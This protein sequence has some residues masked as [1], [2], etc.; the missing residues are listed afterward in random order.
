VYFGASSDAVSAAGRANPS[1][2]LVSQTRDA[3]TYEPAGLLELGKTY[4]WR[5]D[6]VN[7]PPA[8]T[9][10]KG[11]VWSF[12]VEPVA[13]PIT[14][15][16]AT[17]SSYQAGMG[18]EKTIDGS[19]LNTTD[20]HSTQATDMWLSNV[21]GLQPTWIQYEFDTVCK[22]HEMWVWNSNQAI[23]PSFGL[24]IKG[25]TVE[26]STNGTDW[27]PL[28]GVPEF[29]QASGLAGYPHNTTVK[30]AGAVAKY[31]RITANSNWGGLVKQYSLSEVRFF[32]VPVLA[33]EPYPA[34]GSTGVAVDAV[35][36]WRAGREAVSHRVYLSSDE[37][38]VTTGA[39]LAGTTS[40]SRYSTD[41]LEFGRTYY[42]KVNEVNE[43]G[44]PK[45]WEGGIWSFSTV[46]Y[47]TVEDF[48]SYT[49]V[50]GS[51]I[52][53]TWVDGWTNNTGSVVGHLQA[54]FA[55][56]TIIHGGKQSMPLEY[57]N[58]K[59]PFYS[60]VERTFDTPQDWTVNGANTLS[61]YFRG[62]AQPSN[63]PAPLYVVVE[64]KSGHKK[65]VVHPD[66]QATVTVAWQQ[67]RIGL[68]D[69]SSA[70]VNLAA[71]KKMSIG[72]GDR[73]NP[74]PGAAGMVY[75]DDIGVGRPAA[76]Q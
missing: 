72:I 63:A 27:T 2:V 28:S 61:L 37:H 9:I 26:Y 51:R 24:G 8:S 67:W 39:A 43:T 52:Y 23:E 5:V 6:E 13:Y 18:P 32:Y 71:V 69:L 15:I 38:A 10:S 36:D 40:E 35:L 50:E 21:A 58:V 17:A 31:V 20:Q 25:A 12:T 44:S 14:K 45:V 73:T 76:G 53:E 7:A 49:D 34:S 70:G 22:L 74:P 57:N 3:N 41:S 11:A 54:P 16:T 42:W 59:T 60:E 1:G 62:V 4:Y 33:R 29:A 55:E 75:I 56:Q 30:F 47:A 65:T 68:S 19:G 46:E 48:E 66:P 64:D